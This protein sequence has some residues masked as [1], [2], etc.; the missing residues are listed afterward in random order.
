MVVFSEFHLF[1]VSTF[2]FVK[3][4]HEST[5]S[6]LG[7]IMFEFELKSKFQSIK[8][9]FDIIKSELGSCFLFYSRLYP[10]SPQQLLN[11]L[12][13]L[14]HDLALMISTTEKQ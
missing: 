7:S 13:T 6:K 8:Y 1:R 12:S 2:E 10:S 9:E 5:K 14:F 11:N 4:E 3:S